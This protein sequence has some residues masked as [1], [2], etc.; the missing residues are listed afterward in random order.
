MLIQVD[1]E[2]YAMLNRVAPPAKRTRARFVRNALIQ[3]IME[4]EER[5]TRSAYLSHP[6]SEADADDWSTAGEFEK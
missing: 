4:A 5:K 2:V 6:D 1:D 3:A